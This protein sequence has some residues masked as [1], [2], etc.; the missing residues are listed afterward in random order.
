MATPVR[1]IKKESSSPEQHR[2]TIHLPDRDAVIAECAYYKA[3]R[4]GFVPDHELEDWLDAEQE[5]LLYQR[6]S[7]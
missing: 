4:R 7:M 5:F 2:A 6:G 1:K 3:E